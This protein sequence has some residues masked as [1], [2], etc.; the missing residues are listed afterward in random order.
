MRSEKMGKMDY[1]KDMPIAILGAGA[2]GKAAAAD[3]ALAGMKVRLCDLPQFSEKVLA[4]I[5]ERGIQLVGAQDN[6]YCFTRSG[7]ARM[8]MVT[9]DISAAVK[10]AGLVVLASTAMGHEMFFEKLIPALEDGM[11]IHSFTDN[12]ATLLL[13]KMM[14]EKGCTKKVII[15]GWSSAPYGARVKEA[16][17]VLLPRVGIGYRAVTLRGAA[18]PMTDQDDF[19]ESTRYLRCFDAITTGT[20]VVGGK[21]V[22]DINFSNVN[23]VIHVPG[24]V[25]GVST[26]ENW[27]KILGSFNKK[28]YSIYSHAFCPSI[29][30]VQYRFYQEETAIAEAIGVGIQPYREEQFFSHSNVL[31]SEFMN[32][33]YKIPFG[34]L[35][36]E[37]MF[38][39]PYDVHNRYITED[40]PVGC[41]MYHELGKKFGVSTPT[42][43]SFITLA[44]IM[45][46]TDYFSEGY[47]LEY[48]GIADMNR[49]QLLRYLEHGELR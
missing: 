31:G 8:E 4:H 30:R 22:L 38:T 10:G 36:T 42:I 40:V 23:P 47:T 1:L 33:D 39:G 43:D 46:G 2:I 19:L 37:G 3:C 9:D 13:R 48:L 35:Y 15:G 32:D 25:L 44:S 21:T 17:G 5:E 20:G 11:V 34:E 18:L 41:R 16:G 49:D 24:T 26:M 45:T 12:F 7:T 27:G 14:R 28:E 6:L 29:S